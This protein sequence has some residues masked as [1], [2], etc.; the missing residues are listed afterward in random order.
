MTSCFLLV[1]A[2]T[3]GQAN[4]TARIS[5]YL[6][7][8]E[9]YRLKEGEEKVDLDSAAI[10]ISH[11]KQI[12]ARL[13]SGRRDGVI[14]LYES[15][16]IREQGNTAVAKQL[17]TR[18]VSQLLA[19][20]DDVHL[21]QAY[22]ELY[23]FQNWGD[24]LDVKAGLVNCLIGS[25]KKSHDK[26]NEFWARKEMADIHYQ[27]GRLDEAINELLQIAKEQ[28]AGNYPML[29]FTYDLLAGL[30]RAGGE[31][32]KALYYSLETIKNV[33]TAEDSVYLSNF[34]SRVAGNYSLTGSIEEAVNWNTK[35]LNYLLAV[36]QTYEIYGVI[37]SLTPDLIQ[38][39]RVDDALA[40]VVGKSK[41]ITPAGGWEKRSMLLSLARC[42]AAAQNNAM[43][44]KYCEDLIRFNDLRAQRK[45]IS[46]DPNADL[47]LSRFYLNTGQF[48]KAEKYYN[49][50]ISETPKTGKAPDVS[51]ERLFRFKLDSAKGNYVS[52]IRNL[53]SFH[54][55]Y[56]SVYNAAKS[57]QIEELKVSYETDKKEQNIRFLTKQDE[58][59]KSKLKQ[60][61][62]LR[63]I[64][65][66]ALT[67]LVI[68][69]AML[70]N[71]YRLKQKINKQLEERQR[72]IAKQNI[73]LKRLVEEK[74]WLVKEVHH[75]VKNNLQI[76][77]SL[78]NSQSAYIDNEHALTAIYDS[79]H[80]VH[81]MSLIHQKL[82]NTENVSTIDMSVYVRELVT[83]LHDS[84]SNTRNVRFEFDIDAVE[85]DVSQAVPLGLILNEAITNSLKYAFPDNKT[86]VISISLTNIGSNQYLLVIADD[87]I[88]IPLHDNKK[89]GSLGMSLMEGLS[90]DLD[91]NFSIENRNGTTIKI[92]FMH[93]AGIE[94][95]IES[96]VAS[97]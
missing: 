83:Y 43:A 94:H 16:L 42:Y 81:A 17:V 23:S 4:D 27:Q 22:R 15:K 51:F 78:L 19:S 45:E 29:C 12:N 5:V 79:Q 96:S 95:T 31:Y 70:Y 54:A 13:V 90:A 24:S 8:A 2:I 75:R 48:D 88:G 11:A 73:S 7:K 97:N 76:V 21:A 36:N 52:A 9:H 39:G 82:Y 50:V 55:I 69:M 44:E 18:A 20:N 32:N 53:Q 60:G 34:Y 89:A 74:D 26:V 10:C 1:T 92:T 65:F 33:N 77:M 64:S 93:V 61:T 58:L 25:Y 49:K 40:L 28:K 30:Y 57:K 85:M 46:S 59:Q 63:N 14:S 80:R 41:T 38:L 47:F 35:R 3:N 84:F 62:I 66:A 72:E 68:I 87:G 86:G 71:R 37:N 91:G 6:Q 67:L 56:D